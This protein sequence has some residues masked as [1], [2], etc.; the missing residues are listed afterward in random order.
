MSEDSEKR[1]HRRRVRKWWQ[2]VDADLPSELMPLEAIV[3][4]KAID[5][6]G[7]VCLYTKKTKG[8]NVWEA[9]GMLSYALDD[10][11][12]ATTQCAATEEDE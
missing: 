5:G 11:S 3:C 7:D 2:A 4:I 10:Y 9:F 12:S 6:D 8:L 1:E